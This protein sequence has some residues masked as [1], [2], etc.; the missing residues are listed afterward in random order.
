VEAKDLTTAVAPNA[1]V[2]DRPNILRRLR[3]NSLFLSDVKP[4]FVFRADVFRCKTERFS[5]VGIVYAIKKGF[6][7][8]KC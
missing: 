2:P 6:L 5:I 1:A 4:E 7:R 3:R 8:E